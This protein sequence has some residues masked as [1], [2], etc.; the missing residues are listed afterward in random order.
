MNVDSRTLDRTDLQAKVLPELQQ[1]AQTLGVEGHQ[2]LKK[3][4]LIDAI[5]AKA[6][7]DGLDLSGS[8]NGETRARARALGRPCSSVRLHPSPASAPVACRARSA[9][10]IAIVG[11]SGS[12]RNGR[13]SWPMLQCGRGS[14]TC[15][16]RGTA[17]F[18]RA[19]TFRATPT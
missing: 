18:G 7:Q 8:P 3:G 17:S 5:M 19:A 15:C 10:A 6:S 11:G 13:R 2:R 14:L 4:D 9:G 1:M 16:P 12:E